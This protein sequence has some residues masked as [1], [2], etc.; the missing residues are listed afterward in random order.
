MTARLVQPGSGSVR[1]VLV[2][3]HYDGLSEASRGDKVVQAAVGPEVCIINVTEA[4]FR[5]NYRVVGQGGTAP[6]AK[7]PALLAWA[8]SKAGGFTPGPVALLGFSEGCQAVRAHLVDGAEPAAVVLVDGTHA[9]LPKPD[10]A[11]EID[12]YRKVFQAAQAGFP[13]AFIASHSDIRTDLVRP[14]P[15][16]PTKAV[17]ELVTGWSL[18]GKPRD[19]QITREGNAVVY[20]CSGGVASDHVFECREVLPRM[21]RDELS[22]FAPWAHPAPPTVDTQVNGVSPVA[23][24]L[25]PP[26]EDPPAPPAPEELVAVK[27]PAAPIDV[28]HAL[29][30]AWGVLFGVHPPHKESIAILLAQWCLETGRGRSMWC[31]NFGNAKSRSGDGRSWC[32]FA[33]NEVLSPQDVQHYVAGAQPRTDGKPGPNAVATS[34]TVVWFY[35]SHPGCRFRAFHTI[36]E[37]ALDYMGM[38]NR[39][40]ARAWPAVLAGDPAAF[41]H[42]LKMQGYYTADEGQYT[43]GVI[44]IFKEMMALDFDVNE[45]PPAESDVVVDTLPEADRARVLGLIAATYQDLGRELV[46]GDVQR[47]DEPDPTTPGVDA[48]GSPVA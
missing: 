28:A 37:G 35:P 29:I 24:T 34:A 27:T 9:S 36:D 21:L 31:Y 41:S 19:P 38:L 40:F 1:S 10:E 18:E 12:H 45:A 8:S 4:P 11:F 3:Y 33:C 20:S 7:L 30:A 22:K 47:A 13:V 42:A 2:M 23:D 14:T 5:N 39:R 44:A 16:M 26:V 15:Y 25:P 6:L 43:R 48:N 46:D 17:L 32:Y